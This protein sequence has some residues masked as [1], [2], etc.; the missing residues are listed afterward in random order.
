MNIGGAEQ[1]VLHLLYARL[2]HK[3]LYDIGVV[4]TT[5]PFYK[6]FNKGMILGSNNENRSKSKRTVIKPDEIVTSHRVGTLRLYGMFM[7]PLD[8]DVAWSTTGLD[9]A[10]R[11]LDRVWRL[12]VNEEGKQSSIIVD[13]NN[14]SMEKMYH[15]T[16]KK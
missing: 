11:F 4:G 13:D 5:E 8:A 12:F 16:V 3:G 7:G 9:G 6:L 1:A 15:E 14:Q 10:K 2:C